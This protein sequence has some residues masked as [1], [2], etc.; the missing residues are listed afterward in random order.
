MKNTLVKMLLVTRGYENFSIR[1]IVE[2]TRIRLNDLK[3]ED[4]EYLTKDFKYSKSE[5]EDDVFFFYKKSFFAGK[6]VA[7]TIGNYLLEKSSSRGKSFSKI[8]DGDYDGIIRVDKKHRKMSRLYFNGDANI[9]ARIE[10]GKAT[11]V[12]YP[13]DSK[14]GIKNNLK[15]EYQN[16]L[17]RYFKLRFDKFKKEKNLGI[18]HEVVKNTYAKVLAET[19]KYF[20]GENPNLSQKVPTPWYGIM[21]C[22]D[23]ELAK[24]LSFTEDCAKS[25]KDYISAIE[26]LNE[27]P[28]STYYNRKFQ[29]AK[30]ELWDLIKSFK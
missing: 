2:I 22:N 13:K 9:L 5:N 17:K 12:H 8:N 19:S 14:K 20:M 24:I 3:E 26:S 18:S 30:M 11:H 1:R 15:K 27:D 28:N 23:K 16:E 21:G 4:L 10:L 25:Y 6:I 7:I 29:D